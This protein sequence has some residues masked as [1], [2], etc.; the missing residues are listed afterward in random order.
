MKKFNISAYVGT[1]RGFLDDPDT[2]EAILSITESK[3]GEWVKASDVE[4]LKAELK[5]LRKNAE[6]V[7]FQ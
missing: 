5:E 7:E 3:N 2:Q 1:V 4:A 6:W